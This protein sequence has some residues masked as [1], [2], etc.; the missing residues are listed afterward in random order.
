MDTRILIVINSFKRGGGAERTAALLGT[1]LYKSGY[2]VYY[3]TFSNPPYRYKI[4]GKHFDAYNRNN[5]VNGFKKILNNIVNFLELRILTE[6]RMIKN[7][8]EKKKIELIISFMENSNLLVLLSRIL[9]HNHCKIIVSTRSNI[10]LLY[11]TKHIKSYLLGKLI[12]IKILY[13]KADAIVPLSKGVGNIL[14]K[15]I[16]DNRIIRPIYNLFDINFQLK[17][18]REKIS[19][20][21][22][23]IFNDS[24]VYINI[25]RLIEVKGQ[26]HLIK[27]FK[28][29]VDKYEK[30]KLIIL[31]DGDLKNDLKKLVKALNL[32]KHVF[33]IGVHSNIFPFLKKSNCFI[34]TS[35]WEGF[36][37]VLVEALSM[38]LPVISTDCRYGPREILCPEVKVSEKIEY[39]YYGKYGILIEP[40]KFETNFNNLKFFEKEKILSKLM[41][42]IIED[43]EIKNKYSNG[44]KR[45]KDFNVKNIIPKWEKLIN[46]LLS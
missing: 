27:S 15:Y 22:D 41:I 26:I 11:K 10:D 28:N 39:P 30:A 37:N 33:F 12:T 16:P 19:S 24:F 3:L 9:F 14:Y 7:F 42:K 38:N 46:E 2:D 35:L 25:G 6:S 45:A 1:Q 34:F 36:G 18:S 13:K 29:V 31:G 21:H 32:E 20:K 23:E 43:P 4:R 17:L 8:T 44:I 40:F 5:K